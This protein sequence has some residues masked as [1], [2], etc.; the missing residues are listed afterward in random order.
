MPEAQKER[1]ANDTVE[2]IGSF[3]GCCDHGDCN[4]RSKDA[5]CFAAG[6]F[7]IDREFDP[8]CGL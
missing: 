8:A 7:P 4:K 6:S 5:E 2:T 3:S 1:D